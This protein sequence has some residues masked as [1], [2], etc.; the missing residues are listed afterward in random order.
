MSEQPEKPEK[1][2]YDWNHHNDLA[3]DLADL[4]D[5]DLSLKRGHLGTEGLL[6]RLILKGPYG[7]PPSAQEDLDVQAETLVQY[8]E[9]RLR[10]IT[11][12]IYRDLHF[13]RSRADISARFME[14][15]FANYPEKKFRPG[16]TMM[17]ESASSQV[18]CMRERIE[19]LREIVADGFQ[20][21]L[22]A[23]PY[24]YAQE[25]L[26]SLRDAF[27]DTAEP[28]DAVPP[29]PVRFGNLKTGFATMARVAL[30]HAEIQRDLSEQCLALVATDMLLQKAFRLQ[31]SI[32]V[33]GYK[34]VAK[35]MLVS[36]S[37]D[38]DRAASLRHA[39]YAMNETGRVSFPPR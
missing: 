18:S 26:R 3:S 22:D 37:L 38:L 14:A 12:I 23:T 16:L 4:D 5:Y 24:K 6:Q 21:Q 35:H 32:S 7:D 20:D 19:S 13:S 2:E 29:D 1:V 25:R 10:K 8:M 15:V 28:D 9:V 36:A 27:R 31:S 30:T 33:G 34:T 11:S 39:V 17:R